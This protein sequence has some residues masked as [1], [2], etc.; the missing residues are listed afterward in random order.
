MQVEQQ[1]D[2]LCMG[3]TVSI[4]ALFS[5][6]NVHHELDLLVATPWSDV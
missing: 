3:V 5:L 2:V 6:P 4:R 1:L